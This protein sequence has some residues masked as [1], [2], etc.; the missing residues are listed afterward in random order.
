MRINV[1]WE[2]RSTG[3]SV[4]FNHTVKASLSLRCTFQRLGAYLLLRPTAVADRPAVPSRRYS[5]G[6]QNKTYRLIIDIHYYFIN[7]IGYSEDR[8]QYQTGVGQK[9]SVN[10]WAGVANGDSSTHGRP[11]YPPIATTSPAPT[12]QCTLILALVVEPSS[13]A[14]L[15]VSSWRCSPIRAFYSL[16]GLTSCVGTWSHNAPGDVHD[17]LKTG[18]RL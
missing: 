11:V 13:R 16:V 12:R 5:A 4:L 1:C 9:T 14:R 6:V 10:T 3:R 18:L 17:D 2:P 15:P 8:Q 7:R